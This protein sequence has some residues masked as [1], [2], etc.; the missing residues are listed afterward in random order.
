MI[1]MF[2]TRSSATDVA[3]VVIGGLSGDGGALC[4]VKTERAKDAGSAHIDIWARPRTPACDGLQPD[5]GCQLLPERPL[6]PAVVGKGLVGLRHPVD[7]VLLLVRAALLVAR[8][9]QR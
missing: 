4:P 2:R 6:L 8:V 7:V 3:S 5:R 9:H 1:P